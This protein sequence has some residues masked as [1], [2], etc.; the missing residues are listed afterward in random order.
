[1]DTILLCLS[2]QTKFSSKFDKC[3]KCGGNNIIV[4]DEKIKAEKKELTKEQ[5]AT[6]IGCLII[7]FIFVVFIISLSGGKP[8][9]EQNVNVVATP[10]PVITPIITHIRDNTHIP[11]SIEDTTA[12]L[13]KNAVKNKIIIPDG[14]LVIDVDGL[15]VKK[16]TDPSYG[17]FV[18]T[19]IMDGQFGDFFA[20]WYV[21]KNLKLYR[22][23]GKAAIYTP[24]LKHPT[25]LGIKMNDNSE[26]ID[27]L[28][29]NKPM[30]P[31]QQRTIPKETF[32]VLEFQ[33]YQAVIEWATT[34][35]E[36]VKQDLSKQ[37]NLSVDDINKIIGKVMNVLEQCDYMVVIP[38]EQIKLASDYK[39]YDPNKIMIPTPKPTP[40][41]MPEY[42]FT[43]LEYQISMAVRKWSEIPNDP[44]FQKKYVTEASFKAYI[45]RYL[46]SRNK[47]INSLSIQYNTT[48]E[49]IRKICQKVEFSLYDNKATNDLPENQVKYATDYS[50]YN[51]VL[52]PTPLPVVPRIIGTL[53]G[54]GIISSQ[55]FETTKREWTIKWDAQSIW[56]EYERKYDFGIIQILIYNENGELI[57]LVAN[58]NKGGTSQ[59]TIRSRPGKYY[60]KVNSYDVSWTVQ[61]EE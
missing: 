20:I 45:E 34:N 12:T 35:E 21:D 27:F 53:R 10:V 2:C 43:V 18:Y 14:K 49:N 54:T 48:P 61:I 57:D 25:W 60:F 51:N 56:N 22:I 55:T 26:I 36:L 58:Q 37:Y 6:S 46:E 9:N 30:S 50:S 28:Y 17:Y 23:N 24:D 39:K 40:P 8:K 16:H 41:L 15:L 13:A 7:F 42:S 29:H 47:I 32:T 38:E 4:T 59:S 3:P 1:M 5:T 33:I 11:N 31:I 44:F 19:P 52:I